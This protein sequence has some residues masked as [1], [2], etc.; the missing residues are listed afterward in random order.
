MPM[1]VFVNARGG[2]AR[3]VLPALAAAGRAVEV[4]VVEPAALQEAIRRALDAGARRVAVAGGDGS[5]AAAAAVVR[6]ADAELAVIPGGTLNHF[7]GDHGIPLAAEAALEVAL[8]GTVRGVDVATVNDR[9]FMNTSAVGAYVSFV[10]TRKRFQ[11]VVGYRIASLLA[12]IRILPQVHSFRA[13]LETAGE[14]I[15]GETPL[16]FVGVGERAL[17]PPELGRRVPDGRRAL[18]VMLVGRGATTRHWSRAYDRAALGREAPVHPHA[19]PTLVTDYLVEH[20]RVEL[21]RPR[22][23]IATDGELAPMRAPLEYRFHPAALR[24]VGPA[25]ESA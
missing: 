4:H 5:I 2:S 15:T 18:H 23:T 13:R 6:G 21:P 8:R 16:V 10:R 22:G 25:P 24:L 9:L 17:G 11:R 14:E 12:A 20:C 1:P 19:H 3:R 7:A